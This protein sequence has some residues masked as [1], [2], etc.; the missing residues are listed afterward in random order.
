MSNAARTSRF[1]GR[2]SADAL[3]MIKRAA[4]I[5]GR[6]V[7]DFVAAAAEVEARK[8]IEET[9]I[10]RL[11]MEDQLAFIEALTNPPPPNEALKRAKEDYE[12]LFGPL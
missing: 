3:T 4:E 11:S 5:Q 9:H 1:E 10:L 6:S 12:R 8:V 7:S 2:I